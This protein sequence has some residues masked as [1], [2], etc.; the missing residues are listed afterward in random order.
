MATLGEIEE[1]LKIIRNEG[2]EDIVLLH[3][4]SNYPAR[5]EDVN[6]RVMETLKCAFKLPIGFSDHTLGITAPI[7]AVALGACVIEKH[8]TSDKNLPGPDHKAS[9][10]PNELKELVKAIRDVE[11]SLGDGLKRPTKTEEEIKKVARRSIVAKV[12]ILKGTI[13][14][15]D[16]LDV[17]RPGTGIVP[18]YMEMIIGKG[19]KI[20]IK[21]EDLITWEMI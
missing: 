13:I 21:K 6:L 9:L 16:M 18:Q 10:E 5:I 20:D 14:T 4:V 19:A 3:C 12:D 8:F 17:K 11:R 2:V 15:E 1:A 7:A